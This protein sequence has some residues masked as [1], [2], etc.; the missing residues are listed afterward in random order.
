MYSSFQQKNP[1]IIAYLHSLSLMRFW[2]EHLKKK[3]IKK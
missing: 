1:E 2:A 3:K